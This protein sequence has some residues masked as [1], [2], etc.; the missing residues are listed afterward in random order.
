MT[1]QVSTLQPVKQ[2]LDLTHEWRVVAFRPRGD[3]AWD[4]HLDRLEVLAFKKMVD[5]GL[6]VSAHR[7][8]G[9]GTRLLAKLKGKAN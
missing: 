7:R 1:T 2:L 3:G 8:D 6:I 4:W 9:D 5:D